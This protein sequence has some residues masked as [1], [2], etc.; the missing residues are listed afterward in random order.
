MHRMKRFANHYI[1]FPL[2]FLLGVQPLLSQEV[3]FNRVP[4]PEEQPWPWIT[5]ITQ[6][7][8]GFMWFASVN[9]LY[10]HDGLRTIF[11]KHDLSNPNSISNNISSCI[12]ADK[13]GI[14]WIG[15]SG[16]GLDRFDPATQLFS[17]YRHN[18][19]D[20][21]SL[22]S[23]IVQAIGEDREG[24]LWV[25]TNH[26]L[27]RLDKKSGKFTRY[28][29]EADEP[30]TLSCNDIGCIYEDSKGILW[31]GTGD[32]WS[33]NQGLNKEGGL[34]FMDKKTGRFKRF[35]HDPGDASSLIDN[36]V[37]AI[38]EDTR[39]TFWVGTCGDGLHT[40]DRSTGK[41]TRH[42]YDPLQPNKL[43]RPPVSKAL[44]SIEDYITFITEDSGGSVWIGTLMSGLVR[45]DPQTKKTL[46]YYSDSK[47]ESGFNDQSGWAAYTSKDG[48]LWMSTWQQTIFKVDPQQTS[49]QRWTISKPLRALYKD[50][51]EHIW[52]GTDSTFV[53]ITKD[54]N[55][56]KTYPAKDM[57]NINA[58]QE[59]TGNKMWVGTFNGLFLF[60]THTGKS[61]R[62][63]HDAGNSGSLIN[64][65]V[66][67]L[68]KTRDGKLWIG[69]AEG[70]DQFDAG[71][72]R[73]IHF[74]SD[75][76]DSNSGPPF[77]VD[78]LLE[79]A[80]GRLW[81]GSEGFGVSRYEPKTGKFKTF[82]RGSY[83]SSLL[84]DSSGILWAGAQNGFYRFDQSLDAFVPFP[85]PQTGKKIIN[86]LFTVEDNQKALWILTQR[87][88]M[89]LNAKRDRLSVYGNSFGIRPYSR[90]KHLDAIK[91]DQGKIFFIDADGALYSFLPDKLKGNDIP[92]MIDFVNLNFLEQSG[93]GVQN[94]ST[95]SSL[96]SGR[97]LR[98]HYNQNIFSIDYAVLH[99][100]SPENNQHYYMLENYDKTWRQGGS[101][102]KAYY[103]KVPPGQYIFKVKA[104]SYNGIWSEKSI[105]ITILPPWW[106]R[107]WAYTMY[108][109]LLVAGLYAVYRFQRQRL[110]EKEREKARAKELVQAKEI[111][112]AYYKLRSAQAQLIQSEK[113]ASL[114]ELT[115][116]IAHEIQNPLNFVNN[117]SEVNK[118]LLAEMKEEIKKGN[119]DDANAIADDVINNEE[120]INHHG[121]RADSIVKS[122]L[123]HSRG[124]NGVKEPTDINAL[125][126]EY[127]RMSYHGLR[128]KDNSFKVTV[129]TDFDGTIEKINIIPQDIGRVLLNLYTN[130]FYAVDEKKKQQPEI[131]PDDPV[132]RDY[133]PTIWVRTKKHDGKPDSDW[134]EIN[135]R[136]NGN[137]IP[138][139]AL[140]KI[141]QPFFTTK[142]TGQGTG[143]G[144]SLS[145]D[146]VKAHGGEIKAET[147][148]KEGTEFTVVLP[149]NS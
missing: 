61:I 63:S 54:E 139:K 6:D 1:F 92:A 30:G 4:A 86:V 90:R 60:D 43:S 45:Y 12:H 37:G 7:P 25:G 126:D 80:R 127:L 71:A 41:F 74:N 144:L 125:T 29:H 99:Y 135:V 17:H 64:N 134:I 148:E 107:W 75:Q 49:L 96:A 68:H 77:N 70:L 32:C 145:Y 133:E 38:F 143:L 91:T 27:N 112:Q 138:Q 48:V 14:I 51:Q 122:M 62:Y 23:N 33:R 88:L 147:T 19:K 18:E 87:L 106:R 52:L 35:L 76:K 101:D 55:I 132:G 46:N 123:Q 20:A 89:R 10:A 140:D 81:A 120:K 114:G 15:T 82:L 73:F 39:G 5:G 42:Q 16:G 36:R 109:L 11:Y 102:Q 72:R 53:E 118:E 21:S 65:T 57:V 24:F 84:Q 100:S 129:K 117:F 115:A 131:R 141:Y 56:L 119:M 26:G 28:L 13:N 2:L 59:D 95:N 98:L 149:V 142:P 22:S 40:L 47:N 31:I 67:C 136:D 130:A 3:I 34:N 110:I 104:A 85:D 105:A 111:E 78:R 69:T 116:G 108:G 97:E 103:F 113:M 94:A 146:I 8:R 58:I 128:A 66:L 124:S 9:G 137:G 121:K 93:E 44:T 83:I 50:Q 79:D